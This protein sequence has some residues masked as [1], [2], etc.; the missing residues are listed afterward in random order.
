MASC[1]GT[2]GKLTDEYV[3]VIRI[4]WTTGGAEFDRPT[5]SFRDAYRD[6]ARSKTARRDE[7]GQ[8]DPELRDKV[9]R[10][11]SESS[12]LK[13]LGTPSDIALAL[14]YLASDAS[15]FVTGQILAVNGGESM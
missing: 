6:P 13:I 3:D 1:K 5:I 9:R 8:I 2:R 7:T 12:P 14:L 10:G 11:M 4:L 15:R